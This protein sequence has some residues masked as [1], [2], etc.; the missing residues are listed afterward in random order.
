M[1][2]QMDDWT[3]EVGDVRVVVHYGAAWVDLKNGH[4]RGLFEVIRV[5]QKELAIGPIQVFW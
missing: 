1:I 4:W 5:P 2:D 3:V